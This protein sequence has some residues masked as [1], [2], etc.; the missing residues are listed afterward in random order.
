MS[1]LRLFHPDSRLAAEEHARLRR[2]LVKFFDWRGSAPPEACADETLSRLAQ[3]L[4]HTAVRDVRKYA[5]G[6]ARL[7]ALERVRTPAAP[8]EKISTTDVA[9]VAGE[10]GTCL[11]DRFDRCLAALPEDARSLLFRYYEG[12]RGVTLSNRRRLA[13]LLGVTDHALRRRVQRLR[14]RL[15]Q[16][17]QACSSEPVSDTP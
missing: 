10:S 2:A 11:H 17:M 9:G 4:E 14:D 7:V 13:S 6:I 1:A 16:A 5:Y 12:E 3:K 15:E 8:P